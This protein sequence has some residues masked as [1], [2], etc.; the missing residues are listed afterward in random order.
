[1]RSRMKWGD[2]VIIG[3]VLALAGA[4]L[5]FFALR[6]SGDTLY[7]EVWQDDRLVERVE[8]TDTTDRTI[9]LDGHNVIVLSGKTA[10]MQ[11][12]DCPD[13]VCVRT[14]PTDQT[15]SPIACLPNRLVIQ[16]IDNGTS[17]QLDGVS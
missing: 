3:A 7:A 9:D 8:L 13:Q 4:M 10:V 1:M 6:A 16:V 14:G 17:S 11:S 2:F 15:A 12:A 5:A